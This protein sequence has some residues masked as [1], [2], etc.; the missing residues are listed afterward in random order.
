M[1]TT[2][3]FEATV[4]HLPRISV[5]SLVGRIDASAH[6]QLVAA[7]SSVVGEA[8]EGLV[9]DFADVSYINSSGIALL[10]SLISR[11]HQANRRIVAASLSDHYRRIFEITRLSDFLTVAPDRSAALELLVQ[12]AA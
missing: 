2:Q 12:G 4:E 8:A 5:I 3:V 6:D 1:T 10:I 9:L 7:Y 11:A